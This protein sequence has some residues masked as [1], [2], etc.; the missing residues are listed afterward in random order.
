M[1]ALAQEDKERE[2]AV[3]R[4]KYNE[5]IVYIQRHLKKLYEKYY[6][7]KIEEEKAEVLQGTC[8]NRSS[9]FLFHVNVNF[10]L[11]SG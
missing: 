4:L 3:M 6:K 2:L 1:K 10:I 9:I 8:N 11:I 5:E 7:Q